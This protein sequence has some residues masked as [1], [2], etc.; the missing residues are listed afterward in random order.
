MEQEKNGGMKAMEEQQRKEAEKEAELSGE[1]EKELE[2]SSTDKQVGGAIE[3]KT[4]SSSNVAKIGWK[5]NP[6][7]DIGVLAVEFNGGGLYHYYDIPAHMFDEMLSAD[8]V[9]RYI[10]ERIK[11]NYN[12]EKVTRDNLVVAI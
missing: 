2:G 8:S 6:E 9:G 12:F 10:N 3:M 4:C 1:F 7:S 5:G 11:N